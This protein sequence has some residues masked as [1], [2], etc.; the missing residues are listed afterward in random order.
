MLS[1]E[2]GQGAN[3]ELVGRSVVLMGLLSNLVPEAGEEL[4]WPDLGIKRNKWG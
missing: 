4:T 2:L 3:A 1:G